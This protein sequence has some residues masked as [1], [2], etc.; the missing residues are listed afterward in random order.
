MFIAAGLA[1]GVNYV[2]GTSAVVFTIWAT[3][4]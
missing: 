3:I 4:W 2:I 1:V